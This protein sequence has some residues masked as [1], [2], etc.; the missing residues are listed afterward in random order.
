M[1]ELKKVRFRPLINGKFVLDAYNS[2]GYHIEREL[3]FVEIESSMLT[4]YCLEIR[5]KKGKEYRIWFHDI[6]FSKVAVPL[7]IRGYRLKANAFHALYAVIAEVSY[8]AS[9]LS[10]QINRDYLM[11]TK[12]LSKLYVNQD[13]EIIIK[14]L[15]QAAGVK[16]KTPDAD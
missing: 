11:N 2:L 8:Y 12:E 16:E 14:T 9:G 5:F 1:E 3:K 15:L 4:Q 10:S 13:V 6:D 7:Y